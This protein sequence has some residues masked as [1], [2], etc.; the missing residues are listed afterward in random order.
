MGATYDR[1]AS[2]VPRLAVW[3]VLHAV[4]ER[5]LRM[6]GLVLQQQAGWVVRLVLGALAALGFVVEGG[7]VGAAAAGGMLV[8]RRWGLVVDG[9]VD[10]WMFLTDAY[11][12][13]APG[14]VAPAEGYARAAYRMVFGEDETFEAYGEV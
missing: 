7:V 1:P 5:V 4:M 14:L 12:V 11:R 13:L 2:E 6:R 9:V 8:V 3:E 10:C